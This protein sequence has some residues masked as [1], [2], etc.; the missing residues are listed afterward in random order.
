M[1]FI[2]W[3]LKQPCATEGCTEQISR[4]VSEDLIVIVGG[5]SGEKR[6]Y[7][8]NGVFCPI[9]RQQ[10]LNGMSLEEAIQQTIPLLEPVFF[11]HREVGYEDSQ[12][13]L[14]FF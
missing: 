8:Q 4:W 10:Q 7:E 3:I 12:G 14:H 9:C 6:I 11:G 13:K 2:N 5:E 1:G